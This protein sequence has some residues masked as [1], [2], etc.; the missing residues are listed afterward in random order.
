VTLL[1][2]WEWSVAQR[3]GARRNVVDVKESEVAQATVV[4]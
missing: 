4:T 2:R 3:V 1:A